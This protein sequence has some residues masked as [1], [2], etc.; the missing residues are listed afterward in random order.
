MRKQEVERK[1]RMRMA[2]A[3]DQIK[4]ILHENTVSSL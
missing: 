2:N 3:L 4:D 1:R